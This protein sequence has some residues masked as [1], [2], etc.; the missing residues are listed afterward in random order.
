MIGI[1]RIVVPTRLATDAFVR[2][3]FGLA[4]GAA[5]ACP[6]M[7][8]PADAVDIPTRKTGLWEISMDMGSGRTMTMSQCT[9]ATTDKDMSTMASPVGQDTCSRKDF[10]KTATGYTGDSV[11]KIGDKTMTAHSEI[12][13][14]FN[15]AYTVKVTSKTDGGA[16]H[17]MTMNAKWLGP[18]K[19]DQ[20]A[21]DVMMPGGMKMNIKDLQALKGAAP[22]R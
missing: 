3:A 19:A 11:C 15:S 12:T 2:R 8:T 10:E 4:L 9:D 6:M 21:G 20:K 22:K 18:C 1:S 16:S 5:L 13:G 14:D 17:D 7:L